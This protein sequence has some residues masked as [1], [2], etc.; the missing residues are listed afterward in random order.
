MAILA[1]SVKDD[2][3]PIVINWFPF[4]STGSAEVHG[5]AFPNP[6]VSRLLD[7]SVVVIP[8]NKNVLV[9]ES[10]LD[11]TNVTLVPPEM[12]EHRTPVIF[13][14]FPGDA[15]VKNVC[16]VVLSA[17]VNVYE[18]ELHCA[19]AEQVAACEINGT[20]NNTHSQK[21]FLIGHSPLICPVSSTRSLPHLQ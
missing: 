6:L 2:P 18:D 8:A 3:G 15:E 20:A 1:F 13:A 5:L 17:L 9:A 10:T 7:N 16:A 12:L 11:A 19:V 4:S 14:P 21:A